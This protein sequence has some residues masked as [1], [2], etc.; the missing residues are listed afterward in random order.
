M[1]FFFLIFYGLSITIFLEEIGQILSNLNLR[2]FEIYR[3]LIILFSLAF[4]FTMRKKINLNII[5]ILSISFI[6]IFNVFFGKNIKFD[7]SI[8]EYYYLLRYEANYL[9]FQNK[10]KLIIIN[11]YNI[12]LPLIV[13]GFCK[14]LNF[15]IQ[16]F[17]LSSFTL[18]NIFLYLIS[19]LMLYKLILLKFGYI[20]FDYT[21]VLNE[22]NDITHFLDQ[23]K[24]I[25]GWTPR[26]NL[27]TNISFIN[28]HS[29]LLI[30]D[31][32]FI[33]LI[34]RSFLKK[35]SLNF[36]YKLDIFLIIFCFIISDTSIHFLICFIS[37]ITYLFYFKKEVK[38]YLIFSFLIFLIIFLLFQNIFHSSSLGKFF[39]LNQNKF[40][41]PFNFTES[42]SFLFSIYIRI[43]HI[44]YFLFHSTNLDILIGNNIF[45]KNIYT[46]PHNSIVDIFICSGLIG[47]S[48]FVFVFTRLLFLLKNRINNDN[49]FYLN[50]F[51]Q[52]F[53]F[54]N[55]S[56]F[57]FANTIFNIALAACFCF[58]RENDSAI[59]K[60]S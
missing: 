20:L 58:F 3:V 24:R 18:C 55:L 7:T 6:F 1:I 50:I 10:L 42:G 27:E 47:I 26:A 36:K 28:V 49:F 33:L 32:Y 51:I 60:N 8:E 54:S 15:E 44:K 40:S 34:D 57:F 56:G 23:S 19:F 52:S 5:L 29:L 9:F 43:L 13:L 4:F 53:I 16:K 59:I 35:E 21:P 11:L 45:V 17:K 39:D 31:I 22:N 48:L 25:E 37:Y 41:T 12:I 14:N 2:I 38:Y 30:L 46:Y